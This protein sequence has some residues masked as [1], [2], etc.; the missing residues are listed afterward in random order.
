MARVF[1]AQ[2]I[3]FKRHVVVKVLAPEFGQGVSAERFE[4]EIELAAAL[5]QA[6]IVPVITAGE[7]D[8]VPW[9][10]MPYVAGESLR[11]RM[12]AGLIPLGDAVRILADVLRALAYAHERGVVH[13]D[14]KPANVLLSEGTAVVT[15]FGVAK[16]LSASRAQP[17]DGALTMVGTSIGTPAYMAPEQALGDEVDHRADIYSW[18]VM[19]YEVLGGTHPFAGKTSSQLIKAQIA[20]EPRPLPAL[21]PTLPRALTALVERCLRKEASERP[22]DARTLLAALDDRAMLEA[23]HVA[24]RATS[25]RAPLVLVAVL[26]AAAIGVF[27]MQRAT[28]DDVPDVA[29]VRPTGIADSG[30]TRLAVLPFENLGRPEDAYVVD[31]ITDELRSRLSSVPGM[32]VIAR[33]SSNAYRG[34]TKPPEQIATELGV[35]YLLTG[36]LRSEPDSGGN[37]ARFKVSPELVRVRASGAPEAVWSQSLDEPAGDVFQVQTSIATKVTGALNLALA[38]TDRARMVEIP[39]QNP[40]AYDAFLRGEA[41]WEAATNGDFTALQRASS[42][43]ADAVRAD[44]TFVAA[45]AKLSRVSSIRYRDFGRDTTQASLA[46]TAALRAMALAPDRAEPRRALAASHIYL[47]RD[48]RAA[49]AVY[50]PVR[51]LAAGNADFLQG[52]AAAEA[53]V[54]RLEEAVRD[55]LAARALDPRSISFIGEHA[56]HLAWLGRNDE[57]QRELVRAQTM[58]PW[59][60]GLLQVRGRLAISRGDSLAARAVVDDAVRR[61]GPGVWTRASTWMLSDAQRRKKIGAYQAVFGAND[62]RTLGVR[63]EDAWYRGDTTEALRLARILVPMV[64]ASIARTPTDGPAIAGYGTLLAF[65]GRPVEGIAESLRGVSVSPYERDVMTAT[66]SL[67]SL[68]STYLA[69]GMPDKAIDALEDLLS[70]PSDASKG[71]LRIDPTWRS[72]R[73]NPRFQKLVSP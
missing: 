12:D 51:H 44:S 18:G 10:T 43:Y 31:G 66:A 41:N 63:M 50:E 15:D 45:W 2:E 35:D 72:L 70:R 13:R 42:Y 37:R 22:Q 55:G 3:R 32:R 34:S 7:L 21:A 29:G 39:T 69:A 62:A 27:V 61:M 40:A 33:A 4:R 23:G 46:R 71:W 57:A 25:V 17:L 38:G 56:L 16:A 73:G 59:S 52:L 26:V 11:Q 68:A 36:T 58:A 6:N 28:S 8:G 67:M 5:Q 64:K 65:T 20:E 30:L 14:I 60:S 49:L 1:L 48:S 47:N 24:P 19:A 53:G 54:G 9:Y